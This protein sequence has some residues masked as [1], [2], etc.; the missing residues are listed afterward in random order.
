MPFGNILEAPELGTPRYNGQNVGP[1]RCPLQR[2]S[3]VVL[4]S[5]P[6]LI[7]NDYWRI[8]NHVQDR[9]VCLHD[10]CMNDEMRFT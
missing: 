7:E 8:G 2:G 6:R 9:E 4:V 5:K 1:Q 3:T 10:K